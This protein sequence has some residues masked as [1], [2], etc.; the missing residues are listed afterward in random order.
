MDGIIPKNTIETP[1]AEQRVPVKE[2]PAI[3]TS[4]PERGCTGPVRIDKLLEP[5]QQIIN[6]PDRNRLMAELF[7]DYK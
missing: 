3:K 6:H 2:T 5:V 7:R 1:I 4:I